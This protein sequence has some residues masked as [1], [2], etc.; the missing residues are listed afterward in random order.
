MAKNQPA[1]RDKQGRFVKGSSG[2]PSGRPGLPKELIQYAKESPQR[3]REIAD[4]TESL[5]LR[6]DIEK[7]FAEMYYRKAGQRVEV[8]GDMNVTGTTAIKF[9]GLLDDWSK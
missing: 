8:D 6:A 1:N 4:T 7:W 5:K 2:N 3:L 9:E